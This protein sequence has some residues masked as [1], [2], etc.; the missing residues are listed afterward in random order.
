MEGLTGGRGDPRRESRCAG[1]DAQVPTHG[2]VHEAVNLRS[3]P[4]ITCNSNLNFKKFKN[5]RQNKDISRI[6]KIKSINRL[7]A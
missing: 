2:K 7:Q 3:V 6:T 4:F 1:L 5:W